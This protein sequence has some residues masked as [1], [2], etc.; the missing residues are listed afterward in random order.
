MIWRG[1]GCDYNLLHLK[2]DDSF[3]SNLNVFDH[4]FEKYDIYINLIDKND[5]I[6][7]MSGSIR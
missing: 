2:F 5:N 6:V 3:V 1:T 7:L 4:L